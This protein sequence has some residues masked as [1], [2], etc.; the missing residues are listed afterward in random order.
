MRFRDLRV[1]LLFLLLTACRA[2][3]LPAAPA[4]TASF[5]PTVEPA[6]TTTA[7]ASATP[8]PTTTPDPY[9]PY[10]I[11]Y[12]RGRDYG[13]GELEIVE[14]VGA[15]SAFT[16]YLIR[17]PS[18]GLMIHGFMN[19]PQGNGPHPV[20]IALHGYI[21]PSI[22]DTFDYTTH[23]ADALASAGYLVV[24][25]NLRGYPPSDDGDNL[26]RVGMASDVLNLIAI[27]K[28]SAGQPGSLE[29]ADSSR[30][31]MW[32]HSM[33]GGITTRVVTVS[34]DVQAAVLYAAMSGDESRNYE[35][36][37]TWSDGERGVEERA[38]PIE[39]LAQISPIHFLGDVTAAVSIHHGLADEL[40]PVQWSMQT[41]ELL[42]AAGKNVECHFY[43]DMPHTFRGQGDKEFIQYTIQFMNLHLSAR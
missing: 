34:P 28:A 38:V 7:T 43:E 29:A 36:I 20:I 23:Y 9:E 13:G 42:K 39:L 26:F 22:Y 37:G 33:G 6:P 16:R 5:T 14:R 15:N 24:H 41:C 4:A 2:Y 11:A 1:S 18:D 32:G 40:V 10:T 21:E 27:L 19:V 31:G 8:K 17:Y 30:I 25:P 12:L 3:F 35:A